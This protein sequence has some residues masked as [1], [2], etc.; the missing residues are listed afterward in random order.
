MMYSHTHPK[1]KFYLKIIMLLASFGMLVSA[2][3]AYQHFKPVGGPFCNINSYI[4]CD[5]INKS[6]YS[7]IFNIPVAMLGFSAYV[8]IFTAAL[9]L[10][11]EKFPSYFLGLVA[12]FTGASFGFAIYL[13]SMEA[14]VLRA[15]CLYC[16]TSQIIILL[17]FII[18]LNIWLKHRRWLAHSLSQS[19]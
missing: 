6:V 17:I 10:L 13:S 9:G 2:Y 19:S 18:S 3:L 16:V 4:S 5:I 14:F 11:K 1:G 12:L 8:I 15:I 7:E